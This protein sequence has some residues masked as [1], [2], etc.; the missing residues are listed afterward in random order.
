MARLLLI[1][2]DVKLGELVKTYL[3]KYEHTVDHSL[4]PSIGFEN[5]NKNQWTA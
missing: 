5:L 1:E 4:R 2:D 3:E